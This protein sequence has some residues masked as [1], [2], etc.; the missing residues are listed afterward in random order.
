[1]VDILKLRKM[2]QEKVVGTAPEANVPDP[3]PP[4]SGSSSARK[5]ASTGKAMPSTET[6]RPEQKEPGPPGKP[7]H[8]QDSASGSRKTEDQSH[9]HVDSRS[10]GMDSPKPDVTEDHLDVEEEIID[11]VVFELGGRAFGVE[12]TDVQEVVRTAEITRVP[13][14]PSYVLGVMNLRGT[15]TPVIDLHDRFDLTRGE[16]S[17][18]T[19]IIV[20]RLDHQTVGFVVDQ[21][22][23]I[24]HIREADMDTSEHI[25]NEMDAEYIRGV[26]KTGNGESDSST[27]LI[28]LVDLEK[29][30]DVEPALAA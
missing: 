4:G 17:T 9:R 11:L 12:I 16:W 13:H 30:F 24:L 14:A 22:A 21:V 10:A 18:H 28:I 5:P 25:R 19:R 29:I 23:E 20:M 6:L 26:V 15:I 2:D 3:H 27:D 7:D 1:M 8:A